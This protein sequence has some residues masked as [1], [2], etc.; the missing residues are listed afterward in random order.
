[1]A[2]KQE[3]KPKDER[4]AGVAKVAKAR[5]VRAEKIA[6]M[7]KEERAE[8]YRSI[9][10]KRLATIAAMRVAEVAAEYVETEMLDG[11]GESD[12]LP[13]AEVRPATVT[14]IIKPARRGRPPK[15][16]TSTA[17][18]PSLA[19]TERIADP[20]E[21]AF[22]KEIVGK[23]LSIEAV[24]G[25]L[26]CSSRTIQQYLKEGK[27]KGIKIAGTWRISPDNLKRFVNGE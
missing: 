19:E 18:R 26:E 4:L 3:L 2:E 23:L 20:K 9:S 21:L 22:A 24:A 8:Y 11:V 1:M 12:I 15:S 16:L 25:A 7:S 5:A 14:E 10:E 27:L 6:G 17:A 13:L